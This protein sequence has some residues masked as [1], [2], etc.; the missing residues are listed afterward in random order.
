M[1]GIKTAVRSAAGSSA[2]SQLKAGTSEEIIHARAG[3]RDWRNQFHFHPGSYYAFLV[4]QGSN[5]F[6]CAIG[7]ECL[8]ITARYRNLSRNYKYPGPEPLEP[9]ASHRTTLSLPSVQDVNCAGILDRILCWADIDILIRCS[10]SQV[11]YS[12]AI[13]VTYYQGGSEEITF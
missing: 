10:H 9:Q 6:T 4:Q 2:N 7:L 13:E 12:V 3:N 5:M 1:F 11:V 8:G